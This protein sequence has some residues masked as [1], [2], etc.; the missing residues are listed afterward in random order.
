MS[1]LWKVVL[2]IVGLV[3]VG[4][5]VYLALAVNA[6]AST[7]LPELPSMEKVKT[8][9]ALFFSGVVALGFIASLAAIFF[10]RWKDSQAD[11]GVW[12]NIGLTCLGYIIG[13]LAGLFGIAAPAPT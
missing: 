13:V 1:T 6:R 2:L 10:L 8:L 4:L 9:V 7:K 11:I 3:V 5:L 12:V